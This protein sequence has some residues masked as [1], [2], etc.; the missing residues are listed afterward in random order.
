MRNA[1][2]FME[3][4]Q[5]MESTK[6]EALNKFADDNYYKEILNS[7]I[8][9]EFQSEGR[10]VNKENL[11]NFI[12]AKS[13]WRNYAINAGNIVFDMF[14]LAPLVKGFDKATRNAWGIVTGK[15]LS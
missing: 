14:Q 9:K 1:E 13:A 12:A 6:N 10:I 2:N 15:H 7:P 11:A 4:G 5:V 3:A 8:G